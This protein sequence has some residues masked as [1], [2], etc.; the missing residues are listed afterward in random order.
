M[1][2][3]ACRTM[4]AVAALLPAL[5]LAPAVAVLAPAHAQAVRTQSPPIPRPRPDAHVRDKKGRNEPPP[6]AAMPPQLPPRT[7]FIAAEDATAVVPG[8]P[9]ARFWAD[10]VTE[11]NNALPSKP[12]PGLFSPAEAR[13]E[14]SVPDS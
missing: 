4:C 3:D 11:F 10:S 8:I 7:P 5:I 6:I 12:G 2:M 14:L 9:E 13:M 1:N